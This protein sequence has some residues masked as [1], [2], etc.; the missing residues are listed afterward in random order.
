MSNKQEALDKLTGIETSLGKI[1]TETQTL[2]AKIA[3]LQQAVNNAGNIPD[4][5]IEKINAVAN[6][7]RLVDDLVPDLTPLPPPAPV[8]EPTPEGN[9][10]TPDGTS[11]S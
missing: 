1:S 7:A 10:T 3:E 8:V 11:V 4:E 2:I 6:Q 9:G 5:L